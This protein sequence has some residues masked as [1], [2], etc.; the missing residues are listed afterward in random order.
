MTFKN[1]TEAK[2]KNRLY[3]DALDQA[4]GDTDK[5][6]EIYEEMLKS[7]NPNPKTPKSDMRTDIVPKRMK[8]GG[9][10]SFRGG[11]ICKKGMN[12]KA[13]GANS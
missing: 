12:K 8:S 1:L 13:I 5:A 9:R 6:D 7:R 3:L 11:G 4:D 2:F 10:V